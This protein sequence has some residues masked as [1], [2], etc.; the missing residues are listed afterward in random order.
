M[1]FC[2]EEGL[3]KLS[4]IK[5][6]ED[7]VEREGRKNL[8]K[9]DLE[10]HKQDKGICKANF[11]L[12]GESIWNVKQLSGWCKKIFEN[13]AF[14]ERIATTLNFV[15]NSLVGPDSQSYSIKNPEKVSLKPIQMILDMATIYGNLSE[16][17]NFCVSVVRDPRS[18][19][20]DNFN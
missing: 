20:T 6:Y 15:L 11:Q 4:K 8:S 9:E 19:S 2:L 7:R 14:A 5:A 3:V 12:A 17:E 16:I 18:F 10:N 1:T 13:E